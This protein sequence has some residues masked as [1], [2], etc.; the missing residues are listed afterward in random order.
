MSVVSAI[1][2][3]AALAGCSMRTP[4]GSVTDT[5]PETVDAER[6]QNMKNIIRNWFVSTIESEKAPFSFSMNGKSSETFISGWSRK[7]DIRKD[8]TLG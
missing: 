5:T 7:T 6:Y 2:A 8:E 3:A 4:G 1:L